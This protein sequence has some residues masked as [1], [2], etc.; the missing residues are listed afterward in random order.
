MR[1]YYYA[2]HVDGTPG[3]QERE[4]KLWIYEEKKTL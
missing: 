1:T 4:R 2:L 3:M